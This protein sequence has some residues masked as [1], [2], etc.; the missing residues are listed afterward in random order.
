MFYLRYCV[1]CYHH[2]I[3]YFARGAILIRISHHLLRFCKPHGRA[4]LFKKSE[5]ADHLE[6]IR[7][8]M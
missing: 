8:E 6:L 7:L 4:L 5:I 3:C 2:F 1:F